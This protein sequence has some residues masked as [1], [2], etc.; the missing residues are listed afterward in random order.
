MPQLAIPP[1]TRE[2]T[3]RVLIFLFRY[4]A[5]LRAVPFQFNEKNREL[6]PI[7]KVTARVAYSANS[8]LMASYCAHLWVVQALIFTGHVANA[9]TAAVGVHLMFAFTT[10]GVFGANAFVGVKR[11]EAVSL[12]NQFLR[13]NKEFEGKVIG[14]KNKQAF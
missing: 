11:K 12:I 9:P 7:T 13:F 1:A 6:E 5:T 2:T 3:V 14:G 10:L 4:S 8:A